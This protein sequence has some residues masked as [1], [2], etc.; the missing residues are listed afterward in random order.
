MSLFFIGYQNLKLN[1]DRR[2]SCKDAP[3]IIMNPMKYK[4]MKRIYIP[5]T[6]MHPDMQL[7]IGPL[8]VIR[9]LLEYIRNGITY[10][11]QN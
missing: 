6:L 7:G 11:N 4:L 2:C 10:R 1:D 3:T 8:N 5:V 9:V